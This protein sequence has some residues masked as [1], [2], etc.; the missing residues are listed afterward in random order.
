MLDSITRRAALRKIAFASGL[1]AWSPALFAQ[2]FAAASGLGSA[3]KAAMTAI[4][5]AFMAKFNIPGLSVAIARHGRFVYQAGFG[6]ADR[7]TRE[8]VTPESLF[9]I[10]SVSKPI[11]AVGILILM[12][13]G[14]LDLNSKVFG[15]DGI[16]GF[17]YGRDL[18]ERVQKI[19][20][21]QLLTHTCGGWPNDQHDPM[22]HHPSL[23]FTALIMRTI[24]DQPLAYPPGTHYAYSNF[25]YC[26]LGRVIEKL[27][28]TAYP[29]WIR[30]N[31][32]APCGITNMRIARSTRSDR[33]PGEVV[34]Y[35][36]D[37]GDPYAFNIERMDSHGGWIGSARDLVRFAL[38]VDGFND[39]TSLLTPSSIRTMA[40]ATA[41]NPHYA[42]GWFVNQEPNWWHDGNLPGTA[43][44]LVRT[45]HN[46]CWAAL[47]NTQSPGMGLALDRMIWEL[48]RAA[49]SLKA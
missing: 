29:E 16:F 5:N 15:A 4:V 37:G 9:R 41:E 2:Q 6:V 47:A 27:T 11:T 7:Q 8:M 14:Q 45:A 39:A 26:L 1:A 40:T 34:Y 21:G 49:P 46:F 17:D 43:S 24:Y 28:G 20:V 19:T 10:A 13:K 23:D 42:K 31:V 30:K 35:A 33:A 3:E 12:E 32:L 48:V 36:P 25:G 18:P 22:F 38:H 44:I